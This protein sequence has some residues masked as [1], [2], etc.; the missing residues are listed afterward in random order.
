[1]L[2]GEGDVV[3]EGGAAANLLGALSCY[4]RIIVTGALPGA[5]YPGGMTSFLCAHGIRIFDYPK[6]AAPLRERARAV[7]AANG[8]SIEH[9]NVAGSVHGTHRL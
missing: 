6:F 5:C 9:V 7:G 2:R 1:M 8:V 4:D 3:G